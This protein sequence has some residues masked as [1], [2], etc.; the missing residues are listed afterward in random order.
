MGVARG[1][2]DGNE[3]GRHCIVKS[4]GQC[5]L[6]PLRIEESNM[7]SSVT[8]AVVYSPPSG[9]FPYLAVVFL[10]G[11]DEP[12]VTAFDSPLEAQAAIDEIGQALSQSKNSGR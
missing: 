6:L 5:T 3:G 7:R 8:R 2:L 10:A 4:F 1:F 12:I 11:R 9:D